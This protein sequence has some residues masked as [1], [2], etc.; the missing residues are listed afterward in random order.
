M[1]SPV[2]LLSDIYEP[3]GKTFCL[4]IETKCETFPLAANDFVT[5]TIIDKVPNSADAMRWGSNWKSKRVWH[6]SEPVESGSTLCAVKV[7]RQPNPQ[8]PDLCE[9]VSIEGEIPLSRGSLKEEATRLGQ[10]DHWSF[11]SLSMIEVEKED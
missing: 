1:A 2:K 9:P 5:V 4:G 3:M 11:L 6:T 8:T 10:A 7:N